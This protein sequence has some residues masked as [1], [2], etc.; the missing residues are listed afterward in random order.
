MA[1][2]DCGGPEQ[3]IDDLCANSDRGICGRWRYDDTDD[4]PL[5]DEYDRDYS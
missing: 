4:G 5:D 3:C 1:E 2:I